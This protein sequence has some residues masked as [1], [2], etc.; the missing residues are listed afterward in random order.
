MILPGNPNVA[1][2]RSSVKLIWDDVESVLSDAELIVFI[3]YSLP[4]YDSYAKQVF[5]QHASGKEI[6]VFNPSPDDL[7]KYGKVFEGKA[8]LNCQT[9]ES[10][11][12]AQRP[13][14][15]QPH[16]PVSR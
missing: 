13:L 2:E 14:S 8:A 10:C 4:D 16:Q 6:E 1:A 11:A 15:W 9:F 7:E 12:Y 5:R 3:G